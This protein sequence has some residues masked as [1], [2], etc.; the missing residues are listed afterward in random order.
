VVFGLLHFHFRLGHKDLAILVASAAITWD[1]GQG[2]T[3]ISA[4]QNKGG[5]PVGITTNHIWDLLVASSWA[6][7]P[8]PLLLN[9]HIPGFF[10][11]GGGTES[12]LGVYCALNLTAIL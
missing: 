5:Q 12:V 10:V 7:G 3:S 9:H 1:G 2:L 6:L 8:R 4:K 11:C